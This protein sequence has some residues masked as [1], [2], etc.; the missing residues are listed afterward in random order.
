MYTLVCFKGRQWYSS[1]LPGGIARHVKAPCDAVV[2]FWHNGTNRN[3]FYN[4]HPTFCGILCNTT[5]LITE[6]TLLVKR[7]PLVSEMKLQMKRL[8][9]NWRMV[10]QNLKD[11]EHGACFPFVFCLENMQRVQ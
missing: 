8:V 7:V 6:F 2:I 3:A 9:Q 5:K 4:R 10:M 1:A 11:Y